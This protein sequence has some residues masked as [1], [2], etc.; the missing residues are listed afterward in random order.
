MDGGSQIP[1]H[2]EEPEEGDYSS[3]GED[4]GVGPSSAPSVP[5]PQIMDAIAE[6][7]GE[8]VDGEDE[9][10]MM[11]SIADAGDYLESKLPV[12]ILKFY[13]KCSVS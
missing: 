6:A 13:H 5:T 2:F 8:D 11:P 9:R 12:R 4:A 10:P 3:G 1:L 7:D